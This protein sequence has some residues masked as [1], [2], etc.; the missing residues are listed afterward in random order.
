MAE[1]RKGSSVTESRSPV[2]SIELRENEKPTGW[3]YRQLKLGPIA[4]PWYASP[5]SQLILVSFVCFLCPGEL[6]NTALFYKP[7]IS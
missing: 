6:A 4:L 1:L 3:K 2:H 7:L 5:E